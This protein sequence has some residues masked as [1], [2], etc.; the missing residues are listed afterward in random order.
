MLLKN[1]TRIRFVLYSFPNTK[2]K[3]S[4]SVG[5]YKKKCVASSHGII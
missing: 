5:L 1:S 2:R 3:L 4:Y